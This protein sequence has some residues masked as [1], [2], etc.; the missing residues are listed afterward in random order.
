MSRAKVFLLSVFFLAMGLVTFP[1]YGASQTQTIDIDNTDHDGF[2]TEAGIGI[3]SHLAHILDPNMDIRAFLIFLDVEI[4]TWDYLDNATLRLTSASTLPF[5]A[6]SSVTVYGMAGYDLQKLS[7]LAIYSPGSLASFP[8]TS[9]HVNVNTSLFYGGAVL[10]INITDI[11]REIYGHPH[12]D[13]DGWGSTNI[14]DAMG[15]II[16]GA[17]DEIRYFY[18][19][20]GDPARSAE[21]TIGWGSIPL[22]RGGIVPPGSTFINM[23][24][25]W[26]IWSYNPWLN[27]SEYTVWGG[28]S[29]KV[30]NLNDTY[31]DLDTYF[32]GSQLRVYKNWTDDSGSGI[33]G[34]RWGIHYTAVSTAPPPASGRLGLVGWTDDFEYVSAVGSRWQDG[35]IFYLFIENQVPDE[36]RMGVYSIEGGVLR[37][38][39]WAGDLF[40]PYVPYT[41]Y[42]DYYLNMNTGAFTVDT[43]NDLALTSLNTTYTDV[44]APIDAYVQGGYQYEYLIAGWHGG[45]SGADPTTISGAFLSGDQGDFYIYDP[46]TNETLSVPDV[47]G[48]GDVDE[49]D[50]ILL[51]GDTDPHPEAPAP[52]TVWADQTEGPFTRFRMRAYVFMTGF[53]CVWGPI[54]FFSWKRPSAYYLFVGALIIITGL[55]LMLSTTTF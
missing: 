4:N 23:T 46:T 24:D 27:F 50:A 6:D 18:D 34:R 20:L 19:Y 15:F 9:A 45:I 42:Y 54:W 32:G 1:V 29:A 37:D 17:E 35:Y 41:H 51:A 21:L 44:L 43:Y 26:E 55:G 25:G 12:W 39:D 13:G 8:L 36:S 52:G 22:P 49:D 33:V 30:T 16:L 31:F 7:G 14:G 10:D 38:Q 3:D 47:D 40:L 48:D 5:D 11:V 28:A 53:F 2:I